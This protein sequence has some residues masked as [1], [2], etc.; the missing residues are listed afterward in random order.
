[1]FDPFS[2]S[3][4]PKMRNNV[5]D[6]L[7]KYPTTDHLLMRQIDQ[8]LCYASFLY[9]YGWRYATALCFSRLCCSAKC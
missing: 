7:I 3:Y 8:E 9:A 1:M 6:V 5:I 4:K 2:N